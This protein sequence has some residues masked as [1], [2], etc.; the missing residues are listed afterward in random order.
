MLSLLVI[1]TYS[2]LWVYR[3]IDCTVQFS[4]RNISFGVDLTWLIIHWISF[5]TSPSEAID[6]LHEPYFHFCYELAL[7]TSAK[8]SSIKSLRV[9][10]LC[11]AHSLAS[12]QWSVPSDQWT[13]LPT[14]NCYTARNG[15][16]KQAEEP[17]L[18]PFVLQPAKAA[19]MY[20][21]LRAETRPP[22]P[23]PP[24]LLAQNL[25]QNGLR[26]LITCGQSCMT[27]TLVIVVKGLNSEDKYV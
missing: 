11:H 22:P 20:T 21:T 8:C 15:A 27:S 17:Y 18:R 12:L 19:A 13:L 9:H 1:P 25:S 7:E 26:Q 23:I 5:S 3:L 14:E 10:D 4:R 2:D 16:P 24:F 6:T